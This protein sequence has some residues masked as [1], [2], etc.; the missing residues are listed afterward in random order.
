MATREALLAVVESAYGT[1]KTSPVTGTDR[2]YFNLP[3]SDSFQGVMSP[4]FQETDYGGG[5][6][7]PFDVSA[8]HYVTS[9]NWKGFVYPTL[10]TFLINL[11]CQNVTAAPLPWTTTEPVGDLA[12]A[13][14]YK[15]WVTRASATPVRKQF[16]G[17]KGLTLNLDASR[18][19]PRLRFS[20]TL[21]AQE[22]K[23]NS[24]DSSSDP[25]STA[26][27]TPADTLV[28]TGPYLLSHST[29]NVS[30][31]GA[32]ETS[33]ESVSIKVTNTVDVRFFEGHFPTVMAWTG[34]TIEVTVQRLLKSSPNRR[35]QFQ[36]LTAVATYVK[37][38]NG[39]NSFKMDFGSRCHISQYTQQL[40]KGREFLETSTIKA[41][42]DTSTGTDVTLTFT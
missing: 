11:F 30:I 22:E 2:W 34:R 19:D 29:G 4:V 21:A 3:D 16:P 40:G 12:S 28:P 32:A 8:D 42:L 31:G 7:V 37:F 27:P 6:A 24:V 1:P 20:A 35:T 14:F 38:D 13:S 25:D 41:K 18:S 5:I 10:A 15:Y 23:G 9:I 26:F 33:Y 36:G 39:T 17:C